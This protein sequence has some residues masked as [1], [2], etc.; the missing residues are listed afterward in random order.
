MSS[1]EWAGVLG[2]GFGLGAM[3]GLKMTGLMTTGVLA[4]ESRF[5]DGARD[6]S[7]TASFSF[8]ASRELDGVIL[9][10][11][12]LLPDRRG[13]TDWLLESSRELEDRE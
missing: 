4:P 12:V 2:E 6:M 13:V 10:L 11:G 3:A 9:R 8:D 1:D 7:A 5:I